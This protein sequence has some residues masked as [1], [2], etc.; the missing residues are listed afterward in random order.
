[1]WESHVNRINPPN[2]V[3]PADASVPP[4][5]SQLFLPELTRCGFLLGELG[6]GSCSPQLSRLALIH[7]GS[8]PQLWAL[9]SFCSFS[10]SYQVCLVV[11]EEEASISMISRPGLLDSCWCVFF[12]VD[13]FGSIQMFENEDLT[14][15]WLQCSLGYATTFLLLAL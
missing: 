15:L 1:M 7:W 10:A 12:C 13:G 5:A 14:F 6:S 8:N 2:Q 9:L 3:A 4:D 11:S